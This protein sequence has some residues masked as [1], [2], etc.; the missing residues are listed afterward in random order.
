MYSAHPDISLPLSHTCFFTLD[1][2]SYSSYD[3]LFNKLL[4][5]IKFCGE[6]D[7]DFNAAQALEEI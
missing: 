2:P 6:I 5:A 7:N 4:Y 1:I 3:I